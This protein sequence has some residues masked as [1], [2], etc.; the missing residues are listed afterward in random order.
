MNFKAINYPVWIVL[1]LSVGIYG[2][3]LEPEAS[4]QSPGSTGDNVFSRPPDSVLFGLIGS[5][6]ADGLTGERGN[7]GNSN[8]D[9]NKETTK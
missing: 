7:F 6:F 9:H 5:Q 1:L 4:K 3:A 2:A 8:K